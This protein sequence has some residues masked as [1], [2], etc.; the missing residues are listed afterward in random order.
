M[1]ELANSFLSAYEGQTSNI[2]SQLNEL[3]DKNTTAF[4]TK[5]KANELVEGV[6]SIKAFISGQPV[7][8]FLLEKGKA[9]VKDSGITK[10]GA[11]ADAEGEPEGIVGDVGDQELTN[12]ADIAPTS[13][14]SSE[15][16]P[17]M[18]ASR[19]EALANNYGESSTITE[20]SFGEGLIP[21]GAGAVQ[22]QALEATLQGGRG[23]SVA[24]ASSFTQS[25]SAD[26]LAG[27]SDLIGSV[28]K[29]VKESANIS[30]SVAGAEGAGEGAE[31]GELAGE[32]ATAGAL[33][34]IPVVNIIGLLVGAGL[35]IGAGIKKPHLKTP[36]DNINASYQVGI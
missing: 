21:E 16:L 26:V 1:S 22:G 29:V 32:E 20:T 10:E 27:Q 30:K 5:E 13:I 31:G 23:L 24:E 9:F 28:S 19:A 15:G 6:G 2:Q 4:E 25:S 36:V 11:E 3:L 35:A 8:K 17:S 33:D 14:S 12:F 18:L 34:E 7:G